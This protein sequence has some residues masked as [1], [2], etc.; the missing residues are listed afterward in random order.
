MLRSLSIQNYALISSLEI[1][2]HRGFSVITGETGAGKSIIIGALNLILG[3]RA[4]SKSI[5][6]NAEKCVI[7]GVFD[8]SD[9]QLEPFFIEKEWEYDPVQCILRREIWKSGKSRAFINDSPATLTDLKELA[10]FLIDIHSQHENLLLADNRFQL[11]V[12]DI[13]AKKPEIKKQYKSTYDELRIGRSKLQAL[14]EELHKKTQEEDY[15]R[16][17]F[18]QLEDAKLREGEFSELETERDLLSHVEEIKSGL[19]QMGNRLSDDRQGVVS[20]L[21]EALNTARSLS[22][23]YS[24]AE[25]YAERLQ[26]AYIDCKDLILEFAAEQ[27]R[28]DLNPERLQEIRDRLDLIYSLLQKHRL[29]SVEELIALRD[30]LDEEIRKIDR[31]DELIKEWEELTEKKEKELLSLAKDLSLSRQKAAQIL[32]SELTTKVRN[33]GMPD[34]QFNVDIQT[35]KQADTTGIDNVEFLFSANKHGK[36]QPVSQTASGGEI[37]RLMLSIKSLIA[38]KTALPTI[39]FDEIDTGVSGET[40]DKLGIILHQMGSVMQVISITHLPQIAAR[41]DSQL[42]VY[43]EDKGNRTETGIRLLNNEERATEIAHLLSGSQ[44]TKAS[45]ENAKELLKN[46]Y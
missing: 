42:F 29:Q 3:Q 22:K 39:I 40:A 20:G 2:F 21:K 11:D 14:R 44:I 4:D 31:S 30:H 25:G 45:L 46:T 34:L 36:P 8:I 28:L 7:E 1:D 38:G 35:K 9:Y 15:L 24:N 33:L 27:D 17:Q 16:F 37:S 32:E 10:A 13:L 23:L 26:S 41:G 43:K 6:D 19:F 5:R 18:G 12:L